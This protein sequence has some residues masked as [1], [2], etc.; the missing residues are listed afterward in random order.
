MKELGEG[1]KE[2]GGTLLRRKRRSLSW[3]EKS[4]DLYIR[5]GRVGL[6]LSV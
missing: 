6:I 2:K 1:E 3:E 5:G 4:L